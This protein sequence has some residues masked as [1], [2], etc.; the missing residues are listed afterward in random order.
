MK[1]HPK[2]LGAAVAVAA[3][4]FANF[5]PADAASGV[6]FTNSAVD[7]VVVSGSDTTFTLMNDLATAFMESDGCLLTSASFPLTGASP[8][9]NR[10]QSGSGAAIAGDNVYENYDHDVVINYFPQGS[11]VGR[12]QL[13][14]QRAARDPRVPLVDLARSSSAPTTGF[15]CTTANG[16]ELGTTLR[17]IAFARDALSY[18]HW[19]G[20]GGSAVNNLT[21][22]QL[23]DIFI[24]CAITDW[25]QV[26]GTAGTPIVVYTAIPGSGTRSTWDSFL[27]GGSSQNC[28]PAQFQDGDYAN[29]ERLLREHQMEPVEAALNDPGAAN[30]G[31]SIYYMSVGIHNA[32]P[33]A[34]ASSLIGNVNGV[35]PN[36][37]NIVSGTFPFSR[38]MYNVL[39]QS[40]NTP[41]A[42]G[43]TRRFAGML[44]SSATNG[45][46]VGWICK[47]EAYHSE[48]IG[49]SS[50]VGIEVATAN[51][52]WFEVKKA[53]F[54]QNGMYQLA[55]DAFGNRCTFTDVANV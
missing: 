54:A 23:R 37:A 27:G 33:G 50:A 45:Q 5:A 43:A 47:G 18:T 8:T 39:R 19:N 6:P 13:C 11:N 26:G 15:Q 51:Q 21:Q 1:A 29:G 3:V 7:R 20:G 2:M 44:T 42:S 30:E 32:N 22:A 31:N 10:C 48:Q 38:N 17:F 28:I 35:V 12:G 53:A 36:E 41:V 55:P 34:R 24:T 9:Q 52:D 14:N 46:S 40:G 25:G 4:S 49:N 16:G